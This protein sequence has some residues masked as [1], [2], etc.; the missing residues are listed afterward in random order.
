[1]IIMKKCIVVLGVL[2]LPILAMAAD[3]TGTISILRATTDLTSA[4]QQ[5]MFL[6][7]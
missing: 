5:K 1:M 7:S 4:S 3:T 2:L 6:Y